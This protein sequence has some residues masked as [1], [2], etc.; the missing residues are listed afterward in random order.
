[1]CSQLLVIFCFAFG[2]CMIYAW[3]DL[4][5]KTVWSIVI[6]SLFG[7]C[8]LVTIILIALQPKSK[9]ELSFQVFIYIHM[10]VYIQGGVETIKPL[11]TRNV[12]L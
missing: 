3:T 6:T 12:I 7:C 8:M 5:N 4:V 1:M 9:T 10:Y 2:L 11:P